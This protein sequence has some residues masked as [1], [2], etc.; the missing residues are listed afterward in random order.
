MS[1][2][3]H[4]DGIDGIKA[5]GWTQDAAQSEKRLM[6]ELL[7]G[8]D[9]LVRAQ[10]DAFR[11]D[12][13]QAGIGDG[14]YGFQIPL[15]ESLFDGKEHILNVVVE[16]KVQLKPSDIAFQ[17]SAPQRC[18][19]IDLQGTSI[20]LKLENR[21]VGVGPVRYE[22]WEGTRKIL[23]RLEVP[24]GDGAV[25]LPLPS[26]VLDGM[27]HTFSVRVAD[28]VCRLGEI[29][30]VVPSLKRTGTV[31]FSSSV[32]AGAGTI[33]GLAGF[34][35]E[36]LR[37]GLKKA[38]SLSK[39]DALASTLK[40]LV[41]AHEQVTR[42]FAGKSAN[43]DDLEFPVVESP[44]VSVVMPVHNKFSVTYNALA[45][46]LLANNKSSFEVIL[47]DDGST[48]ETLGAGQ[49]LKGVTLVRHDEAQ[50]FIRSCNDGAGRAKGK[51]IV[52]LNNDVEVSDRWIDELV[53]PFENFDG[54][55]LTGSKLLYP[56]GRLQE[57]GGIVWGNGAPWNYGR[58]GNP[59]DPRYSYT[60]QVDYISGAS[61]MVPRDLWVALGGFDEE[62]VPAYYEDTDL[63][64]RVRKAGRKT[65]FAALSQVIHYEGV[66]SGTDTG[67]GI[68]K[69]QKINEPKFRS[70]W[71]KEYRQNGIQGRE[72]DIAKDRNVF[73]RVLMLDHQVPTPDKD[74]G[75]YA[76]VQEIRL[77]QSLGFKVTFAVESLTHFGES[78]QAL[79]RMGVECLYGPYFSWLQDVLERRGQEFDVVYVTRYSVASRVV[80]HIKKYAPQ[81]KI[82]F[83]NADLHFL[84]EMRAAI[85]A[86]DRQAMK[87]ATDT[88]E[89]ELAVMRQVD[90]VLSYNEVEHAVIM[91]HNLNSSQVAKCPW[92]V[93]PREEV[94]SFSE[95]C[96]VAYLGGFGHPPNVEAVCY[97]VSEVMPVLR[98][99]VSGI[100]FLIYG[101]NIPP[102][103]EALAGDDV[104]IKGFVED[105][106]EVYDTCRVLIASLLSGAGIKGK[107]IGALANGL[108]SVLSPVAAEG[109]GI[110]NG[111]E[112]LIAKTP[113]QWASHIES[114]YS[115]EERWG[116][117][118]KAALIFA[119]DQYSFTAGQEL[120]KEAL[121]KVGI[122]SDPEFATLYART[123]SQ[124]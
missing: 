92:V 118:S 81:A 31:P 15:P 80:P 82:V 12:L 102:E 16:G 29:A 24:A 25:T 98:K 109:T 17:S 48:D 5:S 8:K 57:A 72:P 74:A 56:D 1:I 65:V 52:L 62:F 69:Y 89:S 71:A 103:V 78:T 96:D 34:R 117:M 77:L 110:R 113:A 40:R 37:N 30:A 2:R 9:V 87:N 97:F 61:I 108:P 51:Y 19:S 121:E 64:F 27:P 3:G 63:A 73:K 38:M 123:A 116:A 18:E 107:V 6:I 47:V 76:A 59:S 32:A 67:S 13:Q 85:A 28:P 124:T 42:G 95:R 91:S 100:R 46:L 122:H 70:R 99:R 75:S 93:D 120:M 66:S 84:R 112:A 60:R 114:I 4:F 14:A 7:D 119:R 115:D 23:E 55:G 104:V 36:S 58:N 106:A 10:A 44:D 26:D 86:D 90:L 53:W 20:V 68:K 43:F 39:T 50:G 111:V 41:A 45:S 79:Q 88:R 49:I 105:V 11:P 94:P 21:G 33:S 83:N 35:Y 22:V 54:V 101:S